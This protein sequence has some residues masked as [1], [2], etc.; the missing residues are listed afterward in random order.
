MSDETLHEQAADAVRLAESAL[1]YS[2]MT[3]AEHRMLEQAA[4]KHVALI[5]KLAAALKA[6]EAADEIERLRKIEFA[7]RKL[8]AEMMARRGEVLN[9]YNSD[10]W[11]WAWDDLALL[12]QPNTSSATNCRITPSTTEKDDEASP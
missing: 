1:P 6:A 7:A 4:H 10:D 3:Q 9:G 11:S 2:Y 12:L 5:A 8:D